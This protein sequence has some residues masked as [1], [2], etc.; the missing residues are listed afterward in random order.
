MRTALKP[1]GPPSQS[2]VIVT[3]P[4][5]AD[6]DRE[7]EPGA[8]GEVGIER[9]RLGPAAVVD[10]DR[11][12]AVAAAPVIGIEV[13]RARVGRAK[14]RWAWI[15]VSLYQAV[16]RRSELVG[17][18]ERPDV[19]RRRGPAVAQALVERERRLGQ[20]DEVARA[21]PGESA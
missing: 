15:W 13:E 6:A 7:V 2:A 12:A 5:A 4:P 1:V 17:A 20:V 21:V 10:G 16:A 14:I 9:D 3:C 8:V 19:G 11:L 18:L